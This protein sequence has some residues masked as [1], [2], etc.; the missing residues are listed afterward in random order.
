MSEFS[1][2]YY[3]GLLIGIMATALMWALSEIWL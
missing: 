1:Q 2:G 3:T